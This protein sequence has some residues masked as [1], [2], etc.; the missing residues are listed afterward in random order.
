MEKKNGFRGYL[1]VALCFIHIFTHMGALNSLG[2]FM[3]I[4]ASENGFT[5]TQVSLLFSFAG[6]GAALTGMFITPRLLKRFD[7]RICM[8]ISTVLTVGHMVWYSFATRLWEMYISATVAGIAI[9]IGLYAA[10]GAIVGCWFIRNRLTMLGIISAASGIGSAVINSLSGT[11]IVRMGYRYSYL[12][13]SAIVLTVGALQQIFI[14]SRP[15]DIGQEPLRSVKNDDDSVNMSKKDLPGVTFK[16]ALKSPAFYLLFF[17]GI[18]GSISWTGVNMYVV[19][20]LRNNFGLAIDVAS[21]YDAVLRICI[22]IALVFS[23][24]IAEKFGAKVYI[25]YTGMFFSIG[26][27]I[28]IITGKPIASM[29]VLLVAALILLAA[30]ASNSSANAQILA[31]GIFGPKDFTTIQSYLIPGLNIGLA[32]SAVAAAPFVGSDGSVIGCF[33][34]F[35]CCALAWMILA[36]IAAFISPYRKK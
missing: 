4:I 8:A 30:G 6:A 26:V 23:G 12:V 3:P 14:R 10:T 27:L 20:L 11:L 2:V 29:P 19:T 16:E 25:L 36:V 17:A 34:L 18:L 24:K 7:P 13:L 15:E 28:I 21:R 33:R 22:A 1:M 31:N 35:M 32:A 9:G 5:T